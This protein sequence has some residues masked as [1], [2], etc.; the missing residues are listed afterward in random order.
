[1]ANTNNLIQLPYPNGKESQNP[2]KN[3]KCHK[4]L[5]Y[6]DHGPYKIIYVK[7]LLACQKLLKSANVSWSHNVTHVRHT[8]SITMKYKDNTSVIMQH[9]KTKAFINKNMMLQLW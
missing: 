6:S 1:V 5:I 4:N 2:Q 3:P 8:S 7:F 9:N